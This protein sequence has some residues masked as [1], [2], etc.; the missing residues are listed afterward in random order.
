MRFAAPGFLWSLAL[1]PVF[2]VLYLRL[3]RRGARFPVTFTNLDLLAS[4]VPQRRWPGLI[5]PLLFLLAIVSLVVGLARPQALVTLPREEATVVLVLDRSASMLS[6]DVFPNRIEAAKSAAQDFVQNLPPRFQIGVVTFSDVVDVLAQPTVDR[7][8]VQEAIGS[9]EATGSTALGDGVMQALR[10]DPKQ[11]WRH[12]DQPATEDPGP[13]LEAIVLL[14]DGKQTAGKADPL[15]AAA[16]AKELGISVFAIALGPT[17][18]TET[19]GDPRNAPDIPTLQKMAERT[20]GRLFTAPTSKELNEIYRGIGSRLGFVE[21]HQELTFSFAGAGAILA[22]LAIAAG[23][24]RSW[25][26]P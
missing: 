13:P 21:E 19:V 7:V 3:R 14:S 20:E 18:S 5:S 16:R 26:F 25:R 11:R 22:L 24:R 17:D 8:A 1:L 9:L 6:S 23:A 4:V 10:L 12:R 15:E 2:T